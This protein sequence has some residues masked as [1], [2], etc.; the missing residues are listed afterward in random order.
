M[1]TGTM[2]PYAQRRTKLHL[3]RFTRL[4]HD[5]LN[6]KIDDE[7][8]KQIE[9]RDNIFYNMSTAGYYLPNADTLKVKEV[10]R[11][12]AAKKIKREFAHVG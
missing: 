8:L 11:K 7:W 10:A 4:Y 9:A 3:N 6:A 12:A 2:V 5:I 1:K